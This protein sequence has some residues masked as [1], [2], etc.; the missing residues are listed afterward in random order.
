MYI[1]SYIC[2]I[3]NKSD[4]SREILIKVSNKNSTKI[5][6]LGAELFHL[7]GWKDGQT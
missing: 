2:L 6:P 4:V 7:D 5:R 3:L 1:L